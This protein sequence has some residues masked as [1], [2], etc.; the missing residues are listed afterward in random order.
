MLTKY[1]WHNFLTIKRGWQ[2]DPKHYG[3]DSQICFIYRDGVQIRGPF[4]CWS[5]ARRVAKSM[6]R[7][8]IQLMDDK[9]EMF[10]T[11]DSYE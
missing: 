3:E 4:N 2:I 11:S 10:F 7:H 9:F 8:E 1:K 6:I 5:D